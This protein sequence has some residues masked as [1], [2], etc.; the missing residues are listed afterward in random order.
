MSKIVNKLAIFKTRIQRMRTQIRRRLLRI[1]RTQQIWR[2][3]WT[4]RIWRIQWIP[5]I[6]WTRRIWRI[7]IL[8]GI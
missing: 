6:Q 7:R 8:I 5:R 1:W 4:W 2:I 3:Q